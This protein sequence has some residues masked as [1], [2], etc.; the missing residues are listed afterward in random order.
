MNY[1]T[2]FNNF[3]SRRT[4]TTVTNN[5]GVPIESDKKVKVY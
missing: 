5:Q 1:N 4:T 2:N 3:N